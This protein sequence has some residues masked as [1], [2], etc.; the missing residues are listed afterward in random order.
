[1]PNLPA[2]YAEFLRKTPA[3]RIRAGY[4]IMGPD[5]PPH[6]NSTKVLER[7]RGQGVFI[8]KGITPIASMGNGEY[9]AI[10]TEQFK[11]HLPGHVV[12][13]DPKKPR[14]PERLKRSFKEWLSTLSDR[15]EVAKRR[16][17]EGAAKKTAMYDAGRVEILNAL[18]L[19]GRL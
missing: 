8:P 2:D 15:R 11:E 4:E 13:W 16:G 5:G 9:V 6:L 19:S 1:M 10:I 7:L 18:G 3:P 17:G 14:D 12:Y